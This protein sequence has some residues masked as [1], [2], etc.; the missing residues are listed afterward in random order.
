[1]LG[2]V[3][4]ETM[5]L[6][7]FTAALD[8]GPVAIVSVIMAQFSTVAVVLAAVLLHERLRRHQWAGVALVIVATT[9]L[10]ALQAS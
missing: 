3:I 10:A 8:R 9:L 7:A 1:V 6:L 4:L 5:G 2:T